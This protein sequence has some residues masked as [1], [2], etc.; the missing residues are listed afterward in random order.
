MDVYDTPPPISPDHC[1]S[2]KAVTE[3]LIFYEFT[4]KHLK[5]KTN[6]KRILVELPV[7]SPI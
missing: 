2:T 4:L 5:I 6:V 3:D 1:K 7:Y